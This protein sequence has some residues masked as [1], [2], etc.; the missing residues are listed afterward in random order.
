MCLEPTDDAARPC[1][2]PTCAPCLHTWVARGGATCPTCR[3]VLTGADAIPPPAGGDLR[4]A[5]PPGAV[6]VGITLADSVA[7]VRVTRLHPTDLGLACGLRVGDVVTHIN[8]LPM[9][10]H[11]G[12][13][14]VIDRATRYR[15]P[16]TF[17]LRPR[18][19]WLPRRLLARLGR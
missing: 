17:A 6:H 16:L 15:E 12:A 18:R 13:I 14:A 1:G 7:G 10:G 2:H 5:F 19:R 8:G 9:R 4:L 3:G 11:T